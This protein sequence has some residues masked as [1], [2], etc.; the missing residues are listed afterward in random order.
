MTTKIDATSYTL[1]LICGM[2]MNDISSFT[3]W[4]EC[5]DP[6]L[7][8]AIKKSAEKGIEVDKH[9]ILYGNF[10]EIGHQYALLTSSPELEFICIIL[11]KEGSKRYLQR[12]LRKD[13]LELKLEDFITPAQ[14]FAEELKE[15][16]KTAKRI[17]YYG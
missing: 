13:R 12:M 15:R 17:I 14:A 3:Y 4:G 16:A 5:V 2:R 11:S 8:K 10:L 9:D 7:E 6:A 1:G